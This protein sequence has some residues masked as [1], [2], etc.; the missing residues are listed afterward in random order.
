VKG[1]Y[2]WEWSKWSRVGKIKDWDKEG[3]NGGIGNLGEF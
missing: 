3:Q 1:K 2:S